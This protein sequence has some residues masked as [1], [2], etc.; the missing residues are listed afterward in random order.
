MC[1]V[2]S[3]ILIKLQKSTSFEAGFALVRW[4]ACGVLRICPKISALKSPFKLNRFYTMRLIRK[5]ECKSIWLIF[6]HGSL[7]RV[8]EIR[9][10]YYRGYLH[11][12]HDSLNTE[13]KVWILNDHL[14]K[15]L[16]SHLNTEKNYSIIR[17]KTTRQV[18]NRFQDLWNRFPD[19]EGWGVGAKSLSVKA[20]QTDR[21]TQTLDIQDWQCL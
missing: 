14:T 7:Y 18:Y 3:R 11:T 19:F 15:R 13:Q 6:V 10:L 12:K 9:E 20:V 16:K 17:S 8:L 5:S 21:Q 2:G 1:R 4:F